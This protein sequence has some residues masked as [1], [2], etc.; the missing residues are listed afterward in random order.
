MG[1]WDSKQYLKFE[2]ERTQPSRDLIHRLDCTPRTILDVG[3]GPGNSTSALRQRFP[4]HFFTA[5]R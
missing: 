5:K 4:R 1:N 2:K 3:C